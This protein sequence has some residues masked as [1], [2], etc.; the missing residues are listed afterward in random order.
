[1]IY[2]G[3]TVPSLKPSPRST[4]RDGLPRT[5]AEQLRG[6]RPG[7][8]IQRGKWPMARERWRLAGDKVLLVSSRGPQGGHQ[9]RRSRAE[10]T[11]KVM[12]R[13]GGGEV[14]GQW[15]SLAGRELR[16]PVAMEVRPCSVGAEEGR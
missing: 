15:R 3:R 4:G 12:Q 7:G 2:N 1:M 9:A 5:V 14:S 13:G 16:W 8:P 6:P 10:L 11:R